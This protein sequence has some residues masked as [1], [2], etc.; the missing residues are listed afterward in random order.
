[1]KEI[2]EQ[3]ILA[4]N[5][6]K[7]DLNAVQLG[8][9]IQSRQVSL[10]LSDGEVA[11]VAALRT[12]I[13]LLARLSFQVN[14]SGRT[15]SLDHQ[16][17]KLV[18][19]ARRF[20]FD[21]VN[22]AKPFNSDLVIAIG[23]EPVPESNLQGY[24]AGWNV[25]ITN[26]PRKLADAKVSNHLCGA[27]VGVLT[28]SEAFN[29]MVGPLLGK[30]HFPSEI[31]VS[32]LDYS[33]NVSEA[34]A[35]LAELKIPHATLIGCGAVGGAFIYGLSLLPAISG[36]LEIVDSDWITSTNLHRYVLARPVDL[37]NR[38]YKTQRARELLRHYARLNVSEYRKNFSEFLEEH[39]EERRIPF[40][41]SAVDGHAKRRELGRET[42]R[43]ALNAS[44]GSFTFALSTHYQAYLDRGPCVGCHYPA[45]D[46]EHERFALIA[47]ET[48]LEIREVQA[49][50]IT[51]VPMT[52]V[53]LE[54][55]AAFR[56]QPADSYFEFLN[57]PFDSF[58]QHG[59]CGGAAVRSA[60][61][62]T[63][64]PLA[65]VSAAAGILLANELVKR[66]S[67]DLEQ[68][69][70]DNFLQ[71]D[72]LNLTSSWFSSRKRARE[73]CDC[74]NGVYRRRFRQKYD[75]SINSKPTFSTT[76]EPPPP[77]IR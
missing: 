74:R 63:E 3:N 65:H 43:E 58:Y 19:R 25:G 29:R 44:T 34:P 71:V 4:I 59:I 45:N 35:E 41:I 72:L 10:I 14:V 61:G 64:I 40:L 26:S 2:L 12:S 60:S 22:Q 67:P 52:S 6:L 56:G 66:F 48:G 5:Q 18:E 8:E 20:G 75:D 42:T 31:F 73:D 38:V 36:K 32:L 9:L 47:R 46:A 37:L 68:Y 23:V 54:K 17:T 28:A 69:A 15:P 70:L 24:A 11:H 62:L 30:N 50:S 53:L 57:Q 7:V 1:M 27:M 16:T 77:V 55:V 21:N 76:F 39:C 51:N 33:S 13:D 49:L